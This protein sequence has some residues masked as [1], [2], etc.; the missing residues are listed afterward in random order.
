MSLSKPECVHD[1]VLQYPHVRVFVQPLEWTEF[2][3]NLGK[4]K[5]T[6]VPPEEKEDL[7]DDNVFNPPKGQ[8]PL[9]TKERIARR[10][11]QSPQRNQ[12]MLTLITGDNGPFVR[13]RPSG[14]FCFGKKRQVRMHGEIYAKRTTKSSAGFFAFCQ[15]GAIENLREMLFPLHRKLRDNADFLL[16]RDRRLK[17]LVPKDQW[18]DPYIVGVLVELAQSQAEERSNPKYPFA[19]DHIFKTCAAMTDD[20]N[21]EFLYFYSA[22]ISVAF[23]SKFEFPSDLMRPKDCMSSELEVKM[24]KIFFRPYHTF[25]CRI[26]TE[27][28]NAMGEKMELVVGQ[29]RPQK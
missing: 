20:N 21:Q 14:Y 22:E 27:I 1:F 24:K 9:V 13:Q 11:A 12:A 7:S 25:R 15:T 29:T 2:H 4:V 3:M 23:L 8:D 6:E 18:R 5:F 19:E 26:L 10:L 17:P 28:F 16:V